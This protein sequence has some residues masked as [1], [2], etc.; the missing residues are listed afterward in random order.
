MSKQM[1]LRDVPR[2]FDK[3]NAYTDKTY[4]QPMTRIM[5]DL[6]CMKA[7]GWE[8]MDYETLMTVSGFGSSFAYKPIRLQPLNDY[9]FCTPPPGF[10]ER[11][12]AATG[13]AW[14]WRRYKTPAG[15]WKALKRTIDTGAPARVPWME[16]AI[17]A[18]YQEAD[19]KKNRKA[20]VLCEPFAKPGKWWTW[21]EFV[22][23]HKNFSQGWLGRLKKRTRPAPARATAV[24]VLETFVLLARSDPRS[25]TPGFKDVKTG[26]AGIAA[27][28][29]DIAEG[30]EIGGGWAGC[31]CAYPQISGRPSAAMYLAKLAKSNV[32][33]KAASGHVRAAADHYGSA[34]TAWVQWGK[35][36]GH[37]GPKNAWKSKKHRLAGSAAICE[38][39][40]QETLAID[41]IE[42]ALAAMK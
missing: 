15:A 1:L 11:V 21:D 35:H 4:W 23:W 29:D 7:A 9:A 24:D 16:D 30:E 36:L 14:D 34:G 6:V 12:R 32:L 10:G 2:V 31:H 42:R 33:G 25:V 8:K 19:E 39:L 13:A 17:L 3:V 40:K 18:G 26:L 28:A 41:E 20:F 22:D 5:C 37:S 27:Y 38:A